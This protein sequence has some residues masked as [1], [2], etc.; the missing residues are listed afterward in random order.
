MARENPTWGYDRIV[1]AMAN[2]GHKV[3]DQTVGNILKRHDIPPAPKRKQT[4]SWKDFIRSHMAV[5]VGNGLLHR[6]SAYAER[7]EDVLR[8]V[9]LHLESRRI[10]LAG[11][12]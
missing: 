7:T 8:I 3:S 5:M 11:S 2:L 4:T 10:S 12:T 6:G 1:G 9:L